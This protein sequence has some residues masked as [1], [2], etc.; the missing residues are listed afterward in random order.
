[1]PDSVT[2]WTVAHQAS[3]VHGI[4]QARI[5]EWVA[6]SYSR[7]TLQIQGLNP[8]LQCLLHL[9][10]DSLPAEPLGK[11]FQC[12]PNSV[13]GLKGIAVTLPNAPS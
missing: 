10:A 8:Y 6:I 12:P 3:S 4:F 5:L 13:I 1:M 7:V 2:P 9:M 11:L